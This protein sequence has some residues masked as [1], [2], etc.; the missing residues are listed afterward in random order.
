M[1]EIL[2]GAPVA[3]AINER[4]AKIVEKLAGKDT[5]PTLAIIRVGEREDD[6][7]Y[8]KAAIKRCEALGMRVMPVAM[9]ADIDEAT[10]FGCLQ[11]VNANPEIHGILLFRPLPEQLDEEKARNLISPAKD[12]DG[13]SDLALASLLTGKGEGFAPATAQAVIEILDYYQIPIKGVRT[14]V[15]GRSLVIGKPVSLLLLNR[16]ATVTICHSRSENLAAICREND[17]VVAAIGKMETLDGKYFRAGQT[18]IDVGISYN[19]EKQKLCGDVLFEQVEPLV[20]RIT[21]VPKGVGSVTTAILA[22]H[23][24]LAAERTINCE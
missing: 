4:T 3:K 17:I 19:E 11:E 10:F 15:L 18:V 24:A 2:Y 16:H 7:A 5:V 6:L 23:L 13:G 12:L 21:P 14:A 8:E 9:P 1:A 20:E 22:N